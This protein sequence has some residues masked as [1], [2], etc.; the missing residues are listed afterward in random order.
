M[1]EGLTTAS[2]LPQC[3]SPVIKQLAG[4]NPSKGQYGLAYDHFKN[5]GKEQEGID[6]CIALENWLNFKG[7]ETLLGTYIQ[8]L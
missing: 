5:L 2:G 6:M 3:D 8:P 1:I 4:K 7:I